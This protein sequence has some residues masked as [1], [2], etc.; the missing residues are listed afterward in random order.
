M[1]SFKTGWPVPTIVSLLAGPETRRIGRFLCV[2]LLGLAVDATVFTALHGAGLS[3]PLARAAS[4]VCATG[5]TWRLNRALTFAA[6]GRRRSREIARYLSVTL[7]A[8]G[9]SYAFFLTVSHAAPRLP[10]IMVLVTGAVLA[11]GLSFTG[12]RLF[13]FRAVQ[14]AQRRGSPSCGPTPTS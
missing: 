6:T 7:G 9:A 2:G 14:P 11:A 13:T 3:L 4:V 8:Q 1:A 12:Q 5:V 10:A